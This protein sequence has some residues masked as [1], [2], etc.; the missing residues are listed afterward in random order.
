MAL[1]LTLLA[2]QALNAPT[3]AQV[4]SLSP[5]KAGELLLRGRAHGRVVSAGRRVEHYIGVPGVTEYELIEAPQ[6][7][8]GG[9]LRRRWTARFTSSIT[10]PETSRTFAEA[11]PT[12]EI[13]LPGRNGCPDSGYAIMNGGLDRTQAFTLLGLLRRVSTG[14]L[15]VTFSCESEVDP[16]LCASPEATRA[17]LRATRVWAVMQSGGFAEFWLGEPGQL[18]TIVRL[19]SDQPKQVTVV[20][21]IPAPF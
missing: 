6:V 5:V 16:E 13:A 4:E 8:P 11:N 14:D 10:A 20:R 19:P 2:V 17:G 15:Q 7:V 18:V 1:F 9:C 3:L 12:E 21:K